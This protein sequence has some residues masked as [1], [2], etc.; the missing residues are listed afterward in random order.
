MSS[1]SS[2]P[3]PRSNNVP[4]IDAKSLECAKANVELNNLQSRIRV[5]QRKP[6]DPVIPLDDLNIDT[7]DFTMTNPPFYKSE[8]DMLES[9]V[10]KTR[11]PFTACTGAK[12]EMVT[13]GG[14]IG[15]VD[16]I[17]Q[18][19]LVLRERVQW[20][21]AMFGFLSSLVS[22][23]Q[24][25]R[26]HDIDNFAVTEFVQGNKTRRWAVAWSFKAM[27]P[28][29]VFARGTKAAIAKNILPISTR[30]EITLPLPAKIGEFADNLHGAIA[31]LDLISWDWNRECLEGTG[32]AADKVWGRAW[33]RRQKRDMEMQSEQDQI[34]EKKCLLGF[35]VSIHVGRD[36]TVV[37]CRWREGHDAVM[38]ESFRG[39]LKAAIREGLKEKV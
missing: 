30:N 33:R 36:S 37:A 3:L 7:I 2:L 21:T 38:F 27:R 1:Q 25:L 32:R 11:S 39:F 8:E 23:T 35:T 13:D 10:K 26:E 4:D 34:M 28:A 9:A 31:K 14:E 5:V 18:E 29:E 17:F 20:Y 19:S 15:F 16:R 24:K 22:F 6:E 12:V